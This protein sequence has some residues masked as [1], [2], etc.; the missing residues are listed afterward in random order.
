MKLT[1][2]DMY[3]NQRHPVPPAPVVDLTDKTILVTGANTGLG[4]ETAKH[5]ASMKPGKVISA[6]R[7]KQRGEEA[8]TREYLRIS[9]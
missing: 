4:Y 6:C 1:L 5:F 9:R 7:S 8:V 3:K 2:F